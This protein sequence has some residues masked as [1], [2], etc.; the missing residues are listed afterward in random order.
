MKVKSGKIQKPKSTIFFR[1]FLE[2]SKNQ[3]YNVQ[4]IN[5]SDKFIGSFFRR[6]AAGAGGVGGGWRKGIKTKKPQIV[7]LL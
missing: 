1:N 3:Q 4:S 7:F 2:R 6:L 5:P